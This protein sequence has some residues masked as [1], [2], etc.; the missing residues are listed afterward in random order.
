MCRRWALASIAKCQNVIVGVLILRVATGRRI[1]SGQRKRRSGRPGHRL[2][3]RT[4]EEI[5]RKKLHV[6]IGI[7]RRDGVLH[8]SYFTT[9]SQSAH[10]IRS[11]YQIPTPPP[12]LNL[13]ASNSLDTS[14]SVYS[15]IASDLSRSW[16]YTY[17]PGH[18]HSPTQL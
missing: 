2:D 7:Q 1:G 18:L 5:R 8:P 10:N 15:L 11:S 13:H 16:R 6:E 4:A 14:F 12:A 9:A 3:S 17:K